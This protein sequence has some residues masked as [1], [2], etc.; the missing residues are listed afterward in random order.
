[1]NLSQVLWCV[2]IVGGLCMCGKFVWCFEFVRFVSNA[3]R[4]LGWSKGLKVKMHKGAMDSSHPYLFLHLRPF[5]P[6]LFNSLI[7]PTLLWILSKSIWSRQ[8]RGFFVVVDSTPNLNFTIS[9]QME[10]SKVLYFNFN[11]LLLHVTPHVKSTSFYSTF[12][13]SKQAQIFIKWLF[14]TW[15]DEILFGSGQTWKY[16]TYFS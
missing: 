15:L 7:K 8:M 12:H 3:F 4:I 2:C 9:I 16:L 11:L 10:W 1:M 5:T 13:L 6:F 14:L